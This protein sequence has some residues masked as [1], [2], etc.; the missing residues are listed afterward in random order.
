MTKA[1]E[2]KRL[3]DHVESL[4]VRLGGFGPDVPEELREQFRL[5]IRMAEI[6]LE[7]LAL[8]GR[9]KADRDAVIALRAERSRLWLKHD[10]LGDALHERLPLSG[11]GVWDDKAN[12]EFKAAREFNLV[13]AQAMR[14]VGLPDDLID[15]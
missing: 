3:I 4:R 7:L 12:A 5:A 11:L 8:D 1:T 15:F 10:D 9:T 14:A 6:S 2:R 13:E